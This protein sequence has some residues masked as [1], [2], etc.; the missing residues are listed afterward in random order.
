MQISWQRHVDDIDAVFAPTE[1]WDFEMTQ[2]GGGQLGY[3]S[4]YLSLPGLTLM[5]ETMDK[6]LRSLQQMQQQGFFAGVVLRAPRAPLWKGQELRF[7]TPLIFGD[8]AHDMV[9]PEGNLLLT[10]HVPIHIAGPMGLT[11]LAP[12]LWQ[13]DGPALR[14]FAWGCHQVLHRAAAGAAGRAPVQSGDSAMARHLT[15]LFLGALRAPLGTQPSRQFEITRK[16]EQFVTDQGWSETH[17]IDDLASSVGVS[18][19]T[20]HRAFKDLY[21]LGPKGFLRLVRLHQFRDTLLCGRASGV[22]DAALG[23]GFDHFGR[24][25]AYYKAQFGELPR[26]TLLR[27]G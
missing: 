24:A 26:D 22:T 4:C 13:A 11:C 1:D 5:L 7:D 27:A 9:L 12:G 3:R 17:C 25:A 15:G 6:A 19:R 8:V 2:L 20:M 21:G 10:L 16:V 14:R 23:A 18:R